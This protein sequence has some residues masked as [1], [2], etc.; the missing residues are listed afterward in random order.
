LRLLV[1]WLCPELQTD[2]YLSQGIAVVSPHQGRDG[3]VCWERPPLSLS[4][5]LRR[6][7]GCGLLS[8]R[9]VLLPCCFA[10]LLF[11][12]GGAGFSTALAVKLMIRALGSSGFCYSVV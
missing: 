8:N 3:G 10:L 5:L 4:P 9:A 7:P 2:A 11:S 12:A 6:R 1:Y